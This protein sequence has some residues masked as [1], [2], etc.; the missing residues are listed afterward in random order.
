[1]TT[2]AK[3][4]QYDIVNGANEGIRTVEAHTAKEAL[5]IWREKYWIYAHQAKGVHARLV[6]D[7]V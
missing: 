7:E 4:K 1:M 6:K 5:T 3:L 2:Q